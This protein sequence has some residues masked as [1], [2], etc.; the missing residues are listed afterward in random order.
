M[1]HIH[2]QTQRRHWQVNQALRPP[3]PWLC[4]WLF[5]VQ[6]VL[7]VVVGAQVVAPVVADVQVVVLVVVGMQAVVTRPESASNWLCGGR[8][9]GRCLNLWACLHL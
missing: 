7:Q 1:T 8:D 5:D 2:R 9:P 6:G 3:P 4:Q